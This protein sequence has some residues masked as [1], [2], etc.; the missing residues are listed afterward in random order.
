VQLFVIYLKVSDK[1]LALRA[2]SPL[3][4]LMSHPLVFSIS[5]NK[6]VSRFESQCS[7]NSSTLYHDVD[8]NS[9]S[10][11]CDSACSRT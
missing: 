5:V 4:E 6:V 7:L 1:I 3:G 9:R 11:G 2:N 8:R 10:R